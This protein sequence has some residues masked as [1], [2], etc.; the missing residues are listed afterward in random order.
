MDEYDVR[1]R[2]IAELAEVFSTELVQRRLFVPGA[3][4]TP[5]GE[6]AAIRLILPETQSSMVL[7]GLILEHRMLDPRGSGADLVLLDLH[8]DT[9]AL[10]E[11]F[12]TERLDASQP[13]T[14]TATLDRP[15]DVLVVDDDATYR[16]QAALAFRRA[17]DHVRFAADGFEALASALRAKPDVILSDVHM[18]RMDGWQL[19]RMVRGNAKL[20]KVPVVFTSSLAGERERLRGY[21]L[22]VDDFVAKPFRPVELRARA[23]RLV[24]RGETE[25]APSLVRSTIRGDLSQVSLGSVLSLLE[26]EQRCGSLSVTGPVAGVLWIASGCALRAAL[27]QR[28]DRS[29][30]TALQRA[31]RLLSANQGEFFFVA[32][33]DCGAD[34]L[35]TSI[36]GLLMEH[37]RITDESSRADDE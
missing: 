22:G 3:H 32:S 23:E 36:T 1:F 2:S 27:E 37:A 31:L 24:L 6:D 17:G 11:Q 26:L 9:L 18:P 34:E 29:E 28:S 5:A 7:S 25:P 19:L 12:I 35:R 21:Q 30:Y 4:Q 15:L 16:E 33:N 14:V 13:E 8:D 20:A 10:I